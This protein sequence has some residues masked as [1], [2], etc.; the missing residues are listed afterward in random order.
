M[1]TVCE[2]WPFAE[3]PPR[4]WGK[5]RSQK[6]R[7]DYS[8]SSSSNRIMRRSHKGL[9]MQSSP[10]REEWRSTKVLLDHGANIEAKDSD[11]STPLH[12]AAAIGNVEAA[13]VC[14]R[15][16][17]RFLTNGRL[18]KVLLDRGADIEAKDSDGFTP[19][20]TAVYHDEVGVV[21]VSR[22]NV[23]CV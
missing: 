3:G 19:L 16:L 23:R 17:P 18:P 14:R 20:H 8:T 2:E 10:S 7:R 6:R 21:K 13:K 5:Y 22:R 15:S 1:F 9:S 12:Q 11:G 4:P